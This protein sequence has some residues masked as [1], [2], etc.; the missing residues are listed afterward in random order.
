M[1]RARVALVAWTTAFLWPAVALAQLNVV[2]SGGFAGPYRELLPAF[3]RDSGLTVTSTQAASQGGG[4]NTIRALLQ[5]GVPADVVIMSKEGL[6][7][8]IADGRIDAR[9]VVDLAQTPLGVAV[10]KGAPKPVINTVEDFKQVVL[11]AKSVNFVSTTGLY[12][13]Q[14]L[15]PALGIASEVSQKANGDNMASLANTEVDLVLRP[16]SEVIS[17]PGFDFVGPVPGNIQFVSV[18]S[19]AVVT[20]SKQVAAA[21]QLIAFLSSEE[22]RAAARRNGMDSVEAR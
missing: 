14:K 12:L 1:N 9:T 16:V 10:R 17:L 22:A 18:F 2:N 6:N 4:P 15:F 19:A 20:G 7:E 13:T 3:E 5:M 8:L 11:R 21:K